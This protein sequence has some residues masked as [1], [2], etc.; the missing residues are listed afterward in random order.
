MRLCEAS[1]KS[2]SVGVNQYT[3][4]PVAFITLNDEEKVAFG[5]LTRRDRGK[6]LAVTLNGDVISSP[7]IEETIDGG[8]FE[9]SGPEKVILE[10]L[11]SAALSVC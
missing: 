2:V 9:I 5:K 1:V 4:E 10:R 8:I 6:L 11:V 7:R 3:G